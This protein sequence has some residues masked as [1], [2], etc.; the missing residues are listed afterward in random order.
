METWEMIHLLGIILWV[1]GLMNLTRMISFHVGEEPEV[2][3][4]LH[5]IENRIFKFVTL[6][7]L[8]LTLVAGLYMLSTNMDF[9]MK[10]PW[11][12]AKLLFVGFMLGITAILQGKLSELAN[13]NEK[14]SPKAFK[15]A[16]GVTGLMLILILVMIYIRPFA[17]V[18]N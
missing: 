13:N 10:Q 12:H 14:Q 9:Y 17:R 3:K 16:H 18:V 2:Q 8:V 4:R 7:G 15:I 5:Y 6:P 1:G 11:M